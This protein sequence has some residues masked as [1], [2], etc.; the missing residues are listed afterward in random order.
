MPFR[1]GHPLRCHGCGDVIGVYE[2]MTIVDA[3]RARETSVA[4]EP[5]SSAEWDG[6]FHRACHEDEGPPAAG[7]PE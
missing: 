3:G 6:W 5:G 7:R 2:P 4:A 1:P